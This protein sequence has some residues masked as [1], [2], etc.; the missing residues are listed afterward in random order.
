M[1]HIRCPSRPSTYQQFPTK[2]R[3]TFDT[4]PWRRCNPRREETSTTSRQRLVTAQAFSTHGVAGRRPSHQQLTS[5][6]R[7]SQIISLNRP[8]SKPT[9]PSR[10]AA[11][12]PPAPRRDAGSP[13]SSS[14]AAARPSSASPS[15]STS[16]PPSRSCAAPSTAATTR[17]SARAPSAPWGPPSSCSSPR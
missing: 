11:R 1:Q 16:A 9:A 12:R 15:G 3:H 17:P 10:D 2:S 7:P 13:S 4:R 5:H 14:R 6:Q 8:A